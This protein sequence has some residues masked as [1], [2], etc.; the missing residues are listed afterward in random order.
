M[1]LFNINK[2]FYG[3]W[4]V[5]ACFLI[6]FITGGFVFFGFTAVFEPIAN[7][8][9]W[10]YAQV[11]F[12]ASLR[13]L[14]IGLLAPLVGLVVDRWGPRKLIFGGA[15]IVGLGLILLSRTNSLAMFYGVFILIALGMSALSITVL[16]T[17]VVNWFR[18]RGVLATGIAGSGFAIAGLLVPIVTV[19]TDKYDWRT[20]MT[21]IGI[22]IWI[23]VLPLSLLVRHKPEQYGHLP[24]GELI[25]TTVVNENISSMQETNM[26]IITKKIRTRSVFWHIALAQM[27]HMLVLAAVITHVM[28]YLTSIGTSRSISSLVGGAVPLVSIVGRLGSGWIGNRLDKRQAISVFFALMALGML[29]F[30]FLNNGIWLIVPFIILYS[31]AWGGSTTI[32]VALIREYFGRKSFGRIF[33]LMA[34]IATLGRISGA[35]LAGWV[36]D[37]WGTYGGIWF[38][39]A[40]FYLAALLLVLT[41]PPVQNNLEITEK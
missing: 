41:I 5:T 32:T 30:G 22:F 31:S 1:S 25:S 23:I 40:G 24:D 37:K 9:G 26:D 29:C 16:Y 19:L 11:S 7:E 6:S 34:G 17:A 12:A 20:A 8:F 10:S 21:I 39:F 38:V 14:E 4:V 13:G 33:G 27:C 18:K 36:F 3:W 2:V 28:P 15:I 35:P